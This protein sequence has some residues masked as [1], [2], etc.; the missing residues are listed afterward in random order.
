MGSEV[1][2]P[3]VILPLTGHRCGSLGV[4]TPLKALVKVHTGKGVMQ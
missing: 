4:G 2:V 1:R 3:L